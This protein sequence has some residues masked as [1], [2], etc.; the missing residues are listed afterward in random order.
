MSNFRA[1]DI[2]NPDYK[3]WDD[4]RNG[5]EKAFSEIFNGH[6]QMLFRY[7]LKFIS[8]EEMVKDSVQELFIKLYHNRQNLSPT[9]NIRLYLFR[10]LKNKLMD[11]LYS[12]KDT[13]LL[14]SNI[15]PFDIANPEET[16]KEDDWEFIIQKSQL[17]KGLKALTAR[18]REAI[19]LRYTLEMSL[20]DISSLLEMNYQ[21]VRNLIHRS[22]EKLRKE[23]LLNLVLIIYILFN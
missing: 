6:V 21:S 2:N 18:Q 19:Y 10:A 16:D 13:I 7:G 20:E 14:S 1:K 3:L 11:A 5:N 9:D 12:R 23:L 4:F 22:I 8:D 15:L 17:N